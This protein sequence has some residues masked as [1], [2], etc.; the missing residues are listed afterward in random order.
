MPNDEPGHDSGADPDRI[1]SRQDFGHELTALCERAGLTVRDVARAL[2]VPASTVGGYFAGRNLPPVTAPALLLNMLFVCGVEDPAASQKWLDALSRVRRAPGRLPADSPVPYRGLESFQPEDAEWFYG[3]QGL[4]AILVDH[5]RQQYKDGGFLFATGPSGSGKSSVLRAGLI[6]ALR[7]GALDIPGSALWPVTLMTPGA[8]PV[9]EL[10]VQ[11]AALV[12]ADPDELTATLRAQPS[13]CR[14]LARQIGCPENGGGDLHPE[15]SG[16]RARLV[17]VVDQFEEVFTLCQDISERLAFIAALCAVAGREAEGG[18]RRPR[19]DGPEADPAALVALGLRAD[20]YPHALRYPALLSELQRH[21]VLVG[22]MTE[23]ELRSVIVEP[24]NKAKLDIEGGLV[25]ILLRDLAPSAGRSEPAAAHDAGALPLLS[26]ALLTTWERSRRGRL[27]VAD[28]QHSGGIEGAVARTAEEAYEELTSSQQDLA[29]QIFIRLVHVAE[30]T[31]DTRRR[32]PRSELLLLRHGDVQPVIDA[33]VAKRLITAESDD[34]EIAHEALLLAWPRLREWLDNDRAG[35]RIHRQLITAAEVWSASGRDPSSLYGGGRLASVED[36]A[37]DPAHAGDLNMLERQFLVASVEHRV[38]DE[39]TSRNRTRRLQGLVGALAVLSLVAGY[40]AADAYQQE[41]A[42]R[43]QRDLA[44]SRQVATEAGQLRNSDVALAMQLSLAAYQISP[45]TESFSSLIESTASAP[46]TRLLGPAGTE[47]HSVAIDPAKALLASGSGDGTVRLWNISHRGHPRM[48]GRPIA[49]SP[50]AITSVAFAAGG[51]VLAAGGAAGAVWLWDVDNPRRPVLLSRLVLAQ[52][53]AVD[54]I[55]FTHDGRTLAAADSGGKVYFWNTADPRRVAPLG[56]PLSGCAGGTYSV[57]FSPDGRLVAIGGP[58]GCVRL[59]HLTHAA[60]RR[61]TSTSLTGPAKSVNAV[62]FSPDSQTLAAGGS[63]D[64]VWLWSVGSG[65]KPRPDGTPLRGPASWIYSVAFSPDG[66][67]IAAGGADNT[68]YVWSVRNGVLLAALPHP[69]PVLSVIFGGDDYTVATGDADGVVRLWTLPGPVL[70]GSQGS[71]F[72]A[73]F[74]PDSRNLAVA[75]GDG[76]IRV[77]NVAQ[78][79]KPFP[80]GP[81]LSAPGPLDGT[82]AYGPGGRLAA[83]GAD[84]S[85][86]VWDMS[87]VRRPTRLRAPA[88]ALN[89]AIQYVAFDHSGRLM[90]AGSTDGRIEIWD[91]TD[92]AHA[93]AEAVLASSQAGQGHDAFAVALSPNDHLLAAAS[94]DGTVR[95]WNITSLSHPRQFGRPLISLTSAV[96]QVTFS[97]DGHLLAASGEDG[98]VR[99]WNVADPSRPHL[100]STMSGPIGIVYDVSFSPDGHTIAT[101][102]GDKTVSLWNISNPAHPVILGTLTGPSGAVFSATFSPSG[103][104]IAASSQDNTTRLWF[105][106]S[107]LA[108]TYICSVAGDGITRAEWDRYVPGLPYDPPCGHGT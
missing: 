84:G 89:T 22:P 67:A 40:F 81:P 8:E 36:W 14:D 11:L 16:H 47:A 68:A 59:T 56:P 88:T 13:L 78:P 37:A 48:I 12:G 74:S 29:R 10:A 108:G 21:Q 66:K 44:I 60:P 17:L 9:R 102:N 58:G 3:R 35:V 49:V 5:L 91:V 101:A 30:D 85:V 54:S 45:T 100:V 50:G 87:D 94:A 18:G 99:L 95:L 61:W 46:S 104:M 72:T 86:Q 41:A 71:A 63:D 52:D 90:A 51:S 77:W 92:I 32:V 1:N 107:S 43:R 80:D 76:T 79:S 25:E 106:N 39:R 24:A 15:D 69:A 34:V 57:A 98:K 20:F 64:K 23:A 53:A 70:T 4:T 6:P 103:K 97:L 33:F 96:Y 82:L 2:G 27:T 65:R 26:H 105:A 19:P 28:Y 83:G 38:E 73:A 93:R 75:S 42:A 62:T 7:R 31:A 55:A